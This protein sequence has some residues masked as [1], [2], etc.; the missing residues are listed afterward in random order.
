MAVNLTKGGNINLTK[1]SPGLMRLRVGLGWSANASDTGSDFDLDVSAFGLKLDAKGD[2]KLISESWIVFYN[3]LK[4]PG[5]V[6]VH[7]GDCRNGDKEGDDE[8]LIVDISK[9]PTDLEEISFIVTIHEAEQRRQNFGQVR[10]SYIAIY[11]DIT[12]EEIAKYDLEESY[13]METAVQFGSLY[14]KDG[15]WKF[16]AVG[17]GYNIGLDKFIAGYGA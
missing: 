10:K 12:G 15:E 14:K 5:D 11:N 4:S 17:A 7:K 6:I 1:S 9:A 13:S 16:K 8:T 2:P 3:Q